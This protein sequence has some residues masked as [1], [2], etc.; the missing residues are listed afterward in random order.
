M[1]AYHLRMPPLRPEELKK[2]GEVA[3]CL[4]CKH[5]DVSSFPTT[6]VQ[7]GGLYL[8]SS[9]WGARKTESLGLTVHQPQIFGEF[10]GSDNSKTVFQKKKMLQAKKVDTLN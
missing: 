8:Y 1:N 2:P 10:Q 4:S 3:K 7:H 9:C 6:Y 5:K